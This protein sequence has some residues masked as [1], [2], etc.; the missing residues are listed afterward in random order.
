MFSNFALKTYFAFATTAAS[1][2]AYSLDKQ[3]ISGSHHTTSFYHSAQ[4]WEKLLSSS[5]LSA[6]F[7]LNPLFAP[8]LNMKRTTLLASGLLSLFSLSGMAQI[9]VPAEAPARDTRGAAISAPTLI[10]PYGNLPKLDGTLSRLAKGYALISELRSKMPTAKLDSAQL[11]LT[12]PYGV[13][14]LDGTVGFNVSTINNKA[15]A[16][17]LF[18]HQ[19]G[20]HAE[21]ITENFVSADVPISLLVRLSQLPE[22]TSMDM[23]MYAQ[24]LL[25]E[26]R[27]MSHV[28]EVHAGKELYMPFKGKGVVIGVIDRSFE[29]RHAAFLDKDG[30]S[31][32]K[33]LW[34]RSGFSNNANQNQDTKATQDIP[35]GTDKVDLHGEGHGTHVA[36][37]AAGTDVGNGLGGVAPEADLILIPSTFANA[38]ILQ[39]VRFV[40]AQAKKMAQPWVINMSFGGQEGPHDGSSNYDASM[41]LLGSHAGGILVGSAGNDGDGKIHTT[42]KIAVGDSCFVLFEYPNYTN[43]SDDDKENKQMVFDAWAQ[44]T[45]YKQRLQ[46]RPFLLINNKVE[47]MDQTFWGKYS[48]F[49]EERSSSNKRGYKFWVHL[50]R[51]LRDKADNSILFG[52][53][54]TNISQDKEE[55]IHG[56][57]SG[58]GAYKSGRSIPKVA[59]KRMLRGDNKYTIAEAAGTIPNCITVGSYTSKNV[60]KNT[61]NNQTYNYSNM[62]IGKRSYFSSMGPALNP[63]TR[64]PLVLGPGAWINSAINKLYPGFSEKDNWL[65]TEKVKVNG[66][67]YYYADMQGTSMASPFVAGVIALWLEANPNLDYKEITNIIDSTSYKIMPGSI[68]NWTY[69]NGYGRIDAYKGLKMALKKANIDAATGQNI[70]ALSRVS[71]ALQPVT[72]QGDARQWNVLFNN[73]ERTATLTL[74][75]LDGREVERRTLS[76]VQ[77]GHEETFALAHLTPGV[78]LLRITTP[79]AQITRRIVVR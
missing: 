2:G 43:L 38:E 23:P 24:P 57:V 39:D 33:W 65:L 50:P 3:S 28:D 40:K 77:Q 14:S 64:K 21:A 35:V 42:H 69:E 62:A 32:V 70:T 47:Y 46:A 9:V 8:H 56:W 17:A 13:F 18:I 44:S 71:G 74:L 34:D 53:K 54:F 1:R 59:S 37:T 26:A 66:E 20:A 48:Y 76:Q 61:L 4:E 29:F 79:G 73:P 72:L 36:A 78:Y 49:L 67:D 10:A 27:K 63:K 75:A 15:E 12:T 55:E 22:V 60:H 16:V 52:V 41:S 7:F 5:P 58:G 30:N 31:R 19:Q 51:I 11:H 45:D 25:K 68:N 6:P